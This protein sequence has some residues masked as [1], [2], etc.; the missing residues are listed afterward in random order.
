MKT[1]EPITEK[2]LATFA[3]VATR[4]LCRTGRTHRSGKTTLVEACA[5]ALGEY[6]GM[7]NAQKD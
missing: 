3:W 4:G 6:A 2:F 7:S 5:A 1:P